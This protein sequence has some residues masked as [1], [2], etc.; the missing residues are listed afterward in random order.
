MIIFLLSCAASPVHKVK[1]FS[2]NEGFDV[3]CSESLGECRS[4]AHNLCKG[5]YR[6]HNVTELEGLSMRFECVETD[7]AARECQET[8]VSCIL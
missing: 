6:V 3:R 1:L 7:K 2:D 4:F 5:K 8:G